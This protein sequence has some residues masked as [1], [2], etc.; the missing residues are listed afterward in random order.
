MPFENTI[1]NAAFKVADRTIPVSF[2]RFGR[3]DD[4]LDARVG[5]PIVPLLQIDGKQGGQVIANS[6][7]KLP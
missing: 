5:D 7:P 2:D 4:G 1:V 3:L 6:V